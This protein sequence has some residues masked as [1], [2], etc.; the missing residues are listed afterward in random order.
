MNHSRPTSSR[1]S[2]LDSVPALPSR[3]PART[4]KLFDGTQRTTR[5]WDGLRRDSELWV[6]SGDCMVHLY[7]PA[8]SRRGASFRIPLELLEET[9][10]PHLLREC[11]RRPTKTAVSISSDDN[12][13]DSGYG[14][15]VSDDSSARCSELYLSAPL[16]LTR[17]E[18]FSYH[19]GTRNYFAYLL[20]KPIV[21]EDFGVSLAHLW[22]RIEVWQPHS[23]ASEIFQEYCLEQ[24]YLDLAGN[25]E[26]ASAAL[27][28]SELARVQNVWVDAFVHCVG[29][30]GQFD[31]EEGSR[32][33]STT[34]ELIAKASREMHQHV[35]KSTRSLGTFLE[36][37]LGPQNVGLTKPLRD[38][39]DRF[40]SML[41]TYQVNEVGYFPRGPSEPWDRRLWTR[42]YDDFR[43]LYQYLADTKSSTDLASGRG[44]S[45]GL[46]VSLNIQAFDGSKS[47][48]P[49]PYT[50]PLL[51]DNNTR[52]ALMSLSHMRR[53][54]TSLD[55]ESL[56]RAT[57]SD[58]CRVMANPLVQAY[59]KFE[60]RSLE[61]EVAPAEA[62][63]VRWL[64][65][66]GVLQTLVSMT[67]APKEVRNTQTP[68]YPLCVSTKICPSWATK[69]TAAVEMQEAALRRFVALNP[70]V[71][72]PQ[73]ISP[74]CDTQ[75]AS[76]HF[77]HEYSSRRVSQVHVLTGPVS[78]STS[79]RCGATILNRT[80]TGSLA[81][82]SI[83]AQPIGDAPAPAS[84]K[85]STS[86]QEIVVQGYGN[87]T[88]STTAT[89]LD[90]TIQPN[91]TSYLSDNSPSTTYS[92][93]SWSDR[94]DNRSSTASSYSSDSACPETPGTEIS[95]RDDDL[96]IRKAGIDTFDFGFQDHPSVHNLTR[97]HLPTRSSTINSTQRQEK[98]QGMQD[99]EE[100][101]LLAADVPFPSG[102]EESIH[103]A[104]IPFP[105]TPGRVRRAESP[106]SIRS[107]ASSA[108]SFYPEDHCQA[109]DIEESDVRGRRRSRA[110]D[111][112]GWASGTA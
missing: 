63:K 45:G 42:M 61:E 99:I 77:C 3:G 107:E 38:H 111:Q 80:I 101:L 13:S 66:Y 110:L 19:V 39:L 87:G 43:S 52:T 30:E 20:R 72:T 85:R 49:L 84:L 69:E 51:P 23:N 40:R 56:E 55:Q 24:G 7:A 11:L 32:L 2:R 41:H 16:E 18:A 89:G 73:V 5:A 14:A 93:S 100:Y 25:L 57:N 28:W 79:L 105:L 29:M 74:D 112:L 48:Q 9:N 26:Y 76:D 70:L 34:R 92:S 37:E 6:D 15:S 65:V 109:A 82:R 83:K 36:K 103:V 17:A 78:R 35:A 21:G 46:C 47:Y 64:L 97:S 81:R 53:S 106:A 94:D 31:P 54:R 104:D 33:S 88:G 71:E 8:T 12:G 50:L 86:F 75:A 1:S 62:R 68:S 44:I 108:S 91:A 4:V 58:N 90:P 27:Y 22:K 10:S 102:I 96:A 98:G 95:F 60:R 67:N 59:M